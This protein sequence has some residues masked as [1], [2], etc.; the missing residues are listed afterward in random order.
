MHTENRIPVFKGVAIG[1]WIREYLLL[2]LSLLDDCILST[3]SSYAM[4]YGSYP[5]A[6]HKVIEILQKTKRN[7]N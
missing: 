6:F 2:S 4:T 5:K 1:C 7:L 3:F